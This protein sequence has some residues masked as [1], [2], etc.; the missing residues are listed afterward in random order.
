MHPFLNKVQKAIADGKPAKAEALLKK[1]ADAPP[2]VLLHGQALVL[3][4]R[5]Q[6]QPALQALD[7]C[8]KQHPD[9]VEPLLTL[10]AVFRQLQKPQQAMGCYQRLVALAPQDARG[11]AGIGEL[12][13]DAGDLA[14]ARAPLEH[15][16]R[17]DGENREL[18]MRL[19]HVLVQ[20][21]DA[22]AAL[23]WL[24]RAWAL[25]TDSGRLALLLGDAWLRLDDPKRALDYLGRVTDKQ[26]QE[27]ARYKQ[28]SG[29]VAL[30][31]FELAQARIADWLPAMQAHRADLLAQRGIIHT[32]LGEPEPALE[33]FEAALEANPGCAEAWHGLTVHAPARVTDAQLAALE[34]LADSDVFDTAVMACFCQARVF[35]QRAD[36]AAQVRW[37]DKGNALKATRAPVDRARV[38]QAVSDFAAP[39]SEAT[40]A[41]PVIGDEPPAMPTPVFILGL[42]RSGTTLMEQ[43]LSAH[44]QV[45][46]AG[47]SQ[48]L[49]QALAQARDT[50]GVADDTALLA[51]EPAAY[52]RTV[53]QA[54]Q[55][56][57]QRWVQ[58]RGQPQ[59][60]FVTDK[61]I[62]L[63]RYAGL[64]RFAFPE[65]RFIVMQ[66]DPVDVCFGAYKTL[67]AAGQHY[68]YS[69]PDLAW[70]WRLFQ[71]SIGRWQGME[72]MDFHTAQYERLVL[73]QEETTRAVLDHVGIGFEA[74][75]L[76][77]ERNPNAVRTAS[78]SQ[79]RNGF[80]VDAVQRWRRYGALIAPLIQSLEASGVDVRAYG[81][82]LTAAAVRDDNK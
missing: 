67:F 80:Y 58:R 24:E 35:E 75:C 28:V 60:R 32:Y 5:G 64:L 9:Y 6:V 52:I 44:T 41:Q 73:E 82:L 62:N 71:D 81:D 12:L 25:K 79:V 45:C 61:G 55:G 34:A 68:T 57:Y 30:E 31:Q 21:G 13:H 20:L 38:E 42:P 78:A 36:L 72:V 39:F 14:R 51:N 4:A 43:V 29:L 77:F 7:A 53:R 48:A 49:S 74:Q 2:P 66:R 46:A 8:L 40:L 65:A 18:L 70:A 15:A 23:H 16:A 59:A 50:L 10:A 69:Y 3:L 17:L 22:S 63:Y 11:H 47:E 76:E 33:A 37:L 1:R 19:G 56:F 26:L 27:Q 54:M